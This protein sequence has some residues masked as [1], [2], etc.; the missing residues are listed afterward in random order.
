MEQRISDR[1]PDGE[2]YIINRGD[3]LSK[4][5][6]LYYGT[7]SKWGKIYEANRQTVRN[8]HYLYIGQRIIIPPV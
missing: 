5:A 4:L 2:E 1:T 7:Q 3:T 8:P 6:E